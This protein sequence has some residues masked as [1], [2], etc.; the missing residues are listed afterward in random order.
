MV[1][2]KMAPKVL[3]LRIVCYDRRKISVSIVNLSNAC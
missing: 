2:A 1:G 3:K